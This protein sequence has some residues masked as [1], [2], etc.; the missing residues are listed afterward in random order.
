MSSEMKHMKIELF[1]HPLGYRYPPPSYRSVNLKA[2][3]GLLTSPK[4]PGTNKSICYVCFFTLHGKESNSSVCFLGESTARQFAF[5]FYLT[6]G[7]F[8]WKTP[9]MTEPMSTSGEFVWLGAS[10][11][12]SKSQKEFFLKLYCPKY[13]LNM[14][15]NFALP[16]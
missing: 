1:S 16:S 5:W 4:K 14:W 7:A 9:F 2:I 11:K 8:L 6:L 15:Q 10:L 12:V 13:E 3:Y